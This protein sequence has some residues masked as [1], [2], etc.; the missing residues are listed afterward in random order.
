MAADSRGRQREIDVV[1]NGQHAGGIADLLGDTFDGNDG[2]GH[3]M[4]WHRGSRRRAGWLRTVACRRWPPR[5]RA[6]GLARGRGRRARVILVV[7][8]SLSAEYGLARGSGWVALLEQRL[9]E[10]E[11]RRRTVVN[12]SISGDTTSG[13][14]SR[15]PALL[16]AAQA[17]R[18][19]SSS[20]APTTRCAACRW[21]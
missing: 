5:R 9:A 1:E 10:R 19:W 17:R 7:G 11:D 13:G 16:H 6:G 8:D 3:G 14:R 12:A 21:R 4:A 15:L 18:S 20:S 2:I